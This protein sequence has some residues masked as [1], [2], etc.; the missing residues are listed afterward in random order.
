M[1][2]KWF[3]NRLYKIMDYLDPDY[4]ADMLTEKACNLKEKWTPCDLILR[5]YYNNGG[6]SAPGFLG[7]S[8][9]ECIKCY[10]Y[11]I[12]NKEELL[13]LNYISKD[14]WN[15]SGFPLWKNYEIY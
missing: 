1:I 4:T 11:I 9:A 12:E 2:K 3:M 6:G 7:F 5:E 8:R 10:K 13:Q 15:N 14:G